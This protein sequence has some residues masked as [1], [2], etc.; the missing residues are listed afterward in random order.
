GPV[1][2]HLGQYT[3]R[4][5]QGPTRRQALQIGGLSILGLS[6]ADVLRAAPKG[7]REKSCIFLWLD[8][9]PSHFETFDPKP[10]TPDTIRGPYGVIP[11]NVT[12]IQISELL[13]LVAQHMDKCALIRSLTHKT[14][15]H[16]PVPMLTGFNGTTTSYGAVVTRLK[17]P[18][19]DMPAY[20]HLGSKLAVGGGS[21]GAAYDPVEVRDPT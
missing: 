1:M 15:A 9:G 19:G 5:C 20:V 10:N 16:A 6:L 3:A 21:L 17:G 14:D 7:D 13:P 2:L 12:G 8:G 18:T 11:T 4:N